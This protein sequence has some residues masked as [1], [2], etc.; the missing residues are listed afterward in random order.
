MQV[1][2]TLSRD[3]A[4]EGVHNTCSAEAVAKS[5][6]SSDGTSAAAAAAVELK[7]SRLDQ[8]LEFCQLV[9]ETAALPIVRAV[10]TRVSSDFLKRKSRILQ[11]RS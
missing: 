6:D 2:S 8:V 10:V 7:T 5:K 4:V 9:C 3:L 11:T 1:R